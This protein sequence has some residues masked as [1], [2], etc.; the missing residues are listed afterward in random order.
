MTRQGAVERLRGLASPDG[1][2]IDA[3]VNERIGQRLARALVA[4]GEREALARAVWISDRAQAEM[5][6]EARDYDS[7]AS[8]SEKRAYGI[9]ADAILEH[10]AALALGEG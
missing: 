4:P 6:P 9:R 7:Q 3:I 8:E 5:P 10:L 1:S 2:F